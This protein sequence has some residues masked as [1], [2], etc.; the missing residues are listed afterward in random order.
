METDV[1]VVGGVIVNCG[2]YDRIGGV[3][4]DVSEIFRRIY[5]PIR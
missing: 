3:V 5:E 4:V 2:V 1:S